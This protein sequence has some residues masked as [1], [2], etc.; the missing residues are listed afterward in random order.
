MIK[1]VTKAHN[2]HD[3]RIMPSALLSTPN[4]RSLEIWLNIFS[5]SLCGPS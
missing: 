1:I 4:I 5:A 3:M 2:K